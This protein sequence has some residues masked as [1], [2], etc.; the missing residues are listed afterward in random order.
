MGASQVGLHIRC[1]CAKQLQSNTGRRITAW[2]FHRQ[3][4]VSRLAGMLADGEQLAV[5]L[6][7][8]QVLHRRFH[9]RVNLVNHVLVCGHVISGMQM[10]RSAS[11]FCFMSWPAKME[12]SVV[13]TGWSL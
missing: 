5:T 2:G 12:S 8:E 10:G 3:A 13:F 4:L 7:C 11:V 6:D 1:R 9:S